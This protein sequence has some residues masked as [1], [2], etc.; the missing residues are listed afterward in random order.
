MS[1]S[2]RA[3]PD[4]A[5]QDEG[6]RLGELENHLG[7]FVRR[8]QHWIFRDANAALASVDLDVILYSILETI[9]A[10]PGATQ[11]AVAGALGIERARMVA[12]LDDLQQAGLIVRARSEQDRR[13]HALGLTPRGRMILKKANALVAAH[14]KR[15]ARRLGAD[16][17]RRAL[18]A[19]AQFE[20]D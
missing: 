4:G 8:L 18:A 12:L 13:A 14:E 16:N 19:L 9:A 17:Y 7:Y 15:V 2:A 20:S 11:I 3:Q 5:G 6:I 10:N 1:K